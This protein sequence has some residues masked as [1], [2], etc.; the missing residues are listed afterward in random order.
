MVGVSQDNDGGDAGGGVV[1][2]KVNQE[3]WFVRVS[4]RVVGLWDP[5]N[6]ARLMNFWVK[7][8]FSQPG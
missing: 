6:R 1:R 7:N 5:P 8:K 4:E 3:E 2:E